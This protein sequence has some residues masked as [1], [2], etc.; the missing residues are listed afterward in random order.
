[1]FHIEHLH[2]AGG[3]ADVGNGGWSQDSRARFVHA[4]QDFLIECGAVD[5]IGRQAGEIARPDLG[6][7][8][9][10]SNLVV[11][12]PETQALFGNVGLVEILRQS[13]HPPEEVGAHLD[14][15]LADTAAEG[16]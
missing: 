13:E 7:L 4:A 1:M 2:A 12:K 6:R 9:E 5:L 3:E 14:G 10:G 8:I 11:G 15:G 16:L